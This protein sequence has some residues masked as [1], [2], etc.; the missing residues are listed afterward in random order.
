MVLVY[1]QFIACIFM[2]HAVYSTSLLVLGYLEKV[3]GKKA[4][5]LDTCCHSL[6]CIRASVC[7]V[8]TQEV[9]SV[10][11]EPSEHFHQSFSSLV[12][13][14]QALRGSYNSPVFRYLSQRL[15][16]R[17][18]QATLT[19]NWCVSPPYTARFPGKDEFNSPLK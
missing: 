15:H 9:M 12:C 4:I 10:L 14:L 16:G 3:Q 7:C 17:D 1:F 8:H 13:T 6:F 11:I 2:S 18:P 5:L 19:G